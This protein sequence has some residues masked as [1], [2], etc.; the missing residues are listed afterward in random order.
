MTYLT[1]LEHTHDGRRYAPDRPHSD[2]GG[3]GSLLGLLQNEIQ[4]QF[5]A[6]KRFYPRWIKGDRALVFGRRAAHDDLD[7]LISGWTS[8]Q[9]ARSAMVLLQ[10]AGVP[11]G[12]AMAN[13]DLVG[14]PHLADRDFFVTVEQ[15]DAGPLTFPG[16]PYHA[17]GWAPTKFTATFQVTNSLPEIS[18]IR[19]EL[20]TD[21]N[22]PAN[23][24]GRSYKGLFALTEFSVEAALR[25]ARSPRAYREWSRA[26]ICFIG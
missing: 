11:A 23:G 14:D 16:F 1:H 22:L 24:P 15:A 13:E 4:V 17:A 18:A 6:A 9:D 12:M 10:E 8:G 5:D 7:R 2:L 19:L 25:D 26:M 3:T 21:P 20:F